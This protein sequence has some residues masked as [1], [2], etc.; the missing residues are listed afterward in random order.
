LIN[1]EFVTAFRLAISV[2]GKRAAALLPVMKPK[3]LNYSLLLTV[4]AVP[5]FSVVHLL[6]AGVK[7]PNIIYSLADDLGW[8]STPLQAFSAK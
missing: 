1:E 5:L 6:H 7:K 2:A 4:G 8:K 3:L